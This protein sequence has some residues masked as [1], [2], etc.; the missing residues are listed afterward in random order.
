ML[1]IKWL[2]IRM[3]AESFSK[4]GSENMKR[5]FV[6][7]L[8]FLMLFSSACSKAPD[9]ETPSEPAEINTGFFEGVLTVKC[10]GNAGVLDLGDIEHQEEAESM[11]IYLD[12]AEALVLPK[13]PNVKNINIEITER[14]K[15]IDISA[16]ENLKQL[17]LLGKTEKISLPEKLENISVYGQTD[18]SLFTDCESIKN[19]YILGITDIEALKL[20]RNLESVFIMVSGCN[21]TSL[22]EA[23]FSELRLSNVTDDDVAAIGGC[24]VKTLQISDETL[25]DIGFIKKLPNLETVFFEVSS[26]ENPYVTTFMEP[27]EEELDNL[28]TP[29]DVSVLKEFIENGG[30][31]YLKTDPNR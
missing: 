5:L 3:K 16:A 30:T 27:G 6:L 28:K 20:F 7:F 8:A 22:N 1:T 12:S 17:T 11:E 4:K 2:E 31:V 23:S 24:P 21:L 26:G 15:S 10:Y 13:F 25:T 19:V 14:V 29:V 18:L 9:E